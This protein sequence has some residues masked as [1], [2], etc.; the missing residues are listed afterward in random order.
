VKRKRQNS[1]FDFNKLFYR[2]VK[3]G[4]LLYAI[5]LTFLISLISGFV[6]L[7]SYF[8]N[9]Y[10]I[11]TQGQAKL[12]ANVNSA[13][14]LALGNPEIVQLNQKKTIDLFGD[15]E[16][17]VDLEGKNWGMYSVVL[18][19]SAWH[20]YSFSKTAMLGDD[21]FNTEQVALY[22]TDNDNYL[23]LCGKTILKGICYLPKLGPKRAY[24][25]GQ[26]FVG[27]KLVDGTIKPSEKKL[28][29]IN[30]ELI[31]QNKKYLQGSFPTND[32][33]RYF[34]EFVEKDSIVNTFQ[35]RT[36]IVVSNNK[37]QLG[38]K[39]FK[40]N[41]IIYSKKEI[42]IESNARIEDIIVYA[43]GVTVKSG[44]VG[45][46]QIYA[47]DSIRIEG[48]CSIKYPGVVG[49]ICQS[50]SGNVK[51]YLKIDEQSEISGAVFLYNTGGAGR[52]QPLL[53]IGKE[54]EIY[55]QV[56]CNTTT[57]LKGS[58]Y[59]SLYTSG[60]I[61]KTPSSI[62]ENHLLNAEV[63]FSKLSLHFAGISLLGKPK[64]KELIKWLN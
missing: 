34:E 6:I 31:E 60:F 41:I 42:E 47:S 27:S 43:P 21:I 20:N 51:H 63:D 53:S 58:I 25:E 37:I 10:I 3:A 16:C 45:N 14:N 5:F 12:I 64:Q 15:G 40:G 55:G 23:S 49:L 48:N 18:A 57:D 56:Y 13:I 52:I 8:H 39:F 33:V 17:M 36:L 50:Q 11:N 19:S 35:N 30:N 4:A 29:E 46:L 61:L 24:I 32:S 9:R 44:F 28:P 38:Y 62:Y 26:S 59:G 1:T 22:L 54:T 2:K 7:S